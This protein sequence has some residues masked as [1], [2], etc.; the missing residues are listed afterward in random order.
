MVGKAGMDVLICHMG[1]TTGGAI[2]SKYSEAVTLE[3][4]AELVKAYG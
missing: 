3:K 2:G 1:L 4:C